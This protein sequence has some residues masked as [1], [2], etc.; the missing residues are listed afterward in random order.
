MGSKGSK[1]S[2]IEDFLDKSQMSAIHF[3]GFEATDFL[4]D[5]KYASDPNY[6]PD[7]NTQ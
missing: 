5:S 4:K 2:Q 3:L 6:L 1:A 7:D